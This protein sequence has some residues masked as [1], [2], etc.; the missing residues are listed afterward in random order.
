MNP[1]LP[2]EGWNQIMTLPRRLTLAGDDELQI[3]PAGDVE[4]LRYDH[5]HIGETT[6]T[7]NRETVLEGIRGN[8]MELSLEIDAES[9]PMVELNVLRSPNREEFT[10]IMFFKDRGFRVQR[11][12]VTGGHLKNL[13]RIVQS[14]RQEPGEAMKRLAGGVTGTVAV[15]RDD[16]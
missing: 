6:L 11:P 5:R 7:A 8:A 15:F 1:G 10:R 14:V 12:S 13:P 2:T 9:A 4:S 16:R 3:E